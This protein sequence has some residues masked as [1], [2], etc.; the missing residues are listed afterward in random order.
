MTMTRRDLLGQAMLGG[1]LLAG[2][3]TAS[4][5]AGPALADDTIKIGAPFNLTGAL[6]SLD[7]PALNGAKLAAEQINA[8]GGVLGKKIELVV[9]DTKTDPTVIAS[10][11]SQLINQD[12]VP[13]IVGFTDSD[14]VLA[15]APIAEKAGIPFVTPGATSPKLP[16]QVG[17]NMFL[18]CFGDNVQAAAGA[19]F[20]KDTLKA[21][22][23]YLLTDNSTEYTTLLSSYFKQA[24]EKGG[25]TLSLEDN[26]KSGDKSF[27]AQ[28]TKL[29]A[30]GEKPDAL[31]I[32]AMPDDIG[33]IVKQLRQ[34]GVTQPIVGGDGY[35]T[36]LLLSVGGAAANGVYYS[37]HAFMSEDSTAAIKK[38]YA[39]Y[40]TAFKTPPDNAFAALGYDTVGLVA[41]AIKRAGSADPAKIREA[42]AATKGYQG[43][44]G[45]ISYRPGV[46]VPDKTV[47]LI[48]VKGDKLTLS[49]EVLPTWIPAP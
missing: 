33:L 6:S 48:G 8:A 1:L 39:D 15:L 42:L 32:A 31:Y 25:G 7:A 21:K 22:K 19:E 46:R 3:L 18:A 37:T 38:F 17:P 44:T 14:S 41:D 24:F 47:A 23:V 34:S 26:Y 43:I 16:D 36:P 35:D 29:K 13:V 40:Q 11:G 20:L 12:K 10:T 45:A 9:Y 30:L 28:I 5:L 4:G 49:A 2:G 27:T